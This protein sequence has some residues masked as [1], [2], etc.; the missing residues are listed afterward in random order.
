MGWEMR[1][2]RTRLLAVLRLLARAL[3]DD[4]AIHLDLVRNFFVLGNRAS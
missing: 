2:Y 4:S 3:I 1:S